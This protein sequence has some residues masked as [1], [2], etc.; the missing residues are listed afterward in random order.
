M[1][2]EENFLG[3]EKIRNYFDKA[4]QKGFVSHSYLFEG[5]EHTGK[6]T[7]ALRFA[8]KILEDN[9]EDILKNPDLLNVSPDEDKKQISVEKIRDLQKDLGLYPFKAKYK[10]AIIDKAERM[11]RT[12]ANSLLKTL[13]EPGKTSIIILITSDSQKILDTIKSRCQNFSFNAVSDTVLQEFLRKKKGISCPERIAELSQ[14]K[15]GIAVRLAENPE[16]LDEISERSGRLEKILE[17]N[18]AAR[19]EEAASIAVLEREE[20]VEIFDSW[21]ST[22]RKKIRQDLNGAQENSRIGKMDIKKTKNAIDSII[23]SRREILEDNLNVRLSIENLC[24]HI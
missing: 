20:V 2:L 8:A 12:A 9:T 15:P 24:L 5:P 16:L 23:E 22:L 21:I 19:L 18:N 11:N 7:L 6:M 13:E 14:G 4:L 10:V 17:S 3:N 1:I